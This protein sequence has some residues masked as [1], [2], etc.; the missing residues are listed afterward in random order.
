MISMIAAMAKN[1]VIGINNDLP[2]DIPADLERFRAITRGKPCIMGRKTFE[3]IVSRRGG[4]LPN[5]PN[6]VITRGDYTH[7][8]AIIQTDLKAA[9]DF[10]KVTYPNDEIMIIGGANVY[11]QALPHANRLYLTVID[12][13]P[14]GDAFFPKFNE[15]EWKISE[16]ET[17]NDPVP[18][19]NLTLDRV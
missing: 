3:S 10:A 8:D 1:R 17:L 11:E 18:Y 2:W 13:E 5:R 19:K 7:K 6:I 9:I 4:G 12:M 14:V 15:N 16:T